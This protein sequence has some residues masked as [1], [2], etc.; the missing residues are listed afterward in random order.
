MLGAAAPFDQRVLPAETRIVT[1]R[2]RVPP[3]EDVEAA[4]RHAVRH[5]VGHEPLASLAGPGAKVTIAFDDCAAVFPPMAPPDFREVALPV[6]LNELLGSGVELADVHLVCANALHRKWTRGELASVIGQQFAQLWPPHRLYCHDATDPDGLVHLGETPRGFEVEVSRRVIDSD[7]LVYLNATATPFNGG[8]KSVVVGLSSWRSIRHHHRPFPFAGGHSVMDP[9][10]SSFQ[11]L[12]GELGSVVD[13]ELARRG[14]RIFTV[15]SSL[16]AEPPYRVT[17]VTAGHIPD[18]HALTLEQLAREQEVEVEG[19]TD[20]LLLALPPAGP[21]A[22]F[23]RTNPLLTLQLGLGYMFNLYAGRPLVREGG[24][25]ILHADW[26]DDFDRRAHPSYEELYR[27]VLPVTR[28]PFEVWERCA[29]DFS[30]RPEYLYAYRH[31]FGFHGGHP[32]FMWASNAFPRRHLSRII[33][34]GCSDPTVAETL[35]CEGYLTLEQALDAAR[36]HLG[37]GYTLTH[38]RLPPLSVARVS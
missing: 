11:K 9:R 13:A 28:D 14:R 8:W 37:P 10:R 27:E 21:Y 24:I 36:G 3:I 33:L 1:G 19:Q 31:R 29:D 4:V 16:T 30:N 5:P 2:P 34:S 7:L 35:G 25:L 22:A 12:L 32:L 23:S 18:V 6:V 26:T 17:G 38:H 15:E 20:A